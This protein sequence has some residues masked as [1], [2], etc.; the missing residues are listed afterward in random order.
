MQEIFFL[1]W[2]F[3][4]QVA[5]LTDFGYA[6]FWVIFLAGLLRVLDKVWRVC[7]LGIM[8]SQHGKLNVANVS[9]AKQARATS[10]MSSCTILQREWCRQTK[11]HDSQPWMAIPFT[12]FLELPLSASTRCWTRLIV[13]KWIP[14]HLL[15][16]S[17]CLDVVLLQVILNPFF[18]IGIMNLGLLD[19][20]KIWFPTWWKNLLWTQENSPIASDWLLSCAQELDLLGELEKFHLD[21]RLQ[22]LDWVQWD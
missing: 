15:R 6:L 1:C 12:T 19:K 2:I 9:I 10:V 14:K 22:C 4:I 11:R 5:V 20:C 3:F 18:L 17:A 16:K 21:L 13:L 7:N 8:W